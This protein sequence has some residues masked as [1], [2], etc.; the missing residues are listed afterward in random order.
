ML[1][2]LDLAWNQDNFVSVHFCE[3]HDFDPIAAELATKNVTVMPIDG[4][5][6]RDE[7]GLYRAFAV[8]LRM[9]RG[10]YGDEE[11]A[12][13]PNAFLEYLDDVPEWVRAN[14]HVAV[15]TGSEHFWREQPRIAGL[16][17]ELWQSATT[18]RGAKIHLVFEW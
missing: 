10:W 2:L 7:E 9:P 13:N 17:V 18:R 15:I 16:L 6:I 11:Y 4:T 14:G 12:P 5:S 3:K 1:S 8:A